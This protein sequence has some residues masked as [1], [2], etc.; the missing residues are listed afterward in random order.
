MRGQRGQ[1]AAGS[2]SDNICCCCRVCHLRAAPSSWLGTKRFCFT[3]TE[4]KA[5]SKKTH[6]GTKGS[7][8]HLGNEKESNTKHS[9]GAGWAP[10]AGWAGQ[11]EGCRDPGRDGLCCSEGSH[12][13]G[14]IK[15]PR[16][17]QQGWREHRKLLGW[18]LLDFPRY[19][20]IWIFQ[21]P[22]PWGIQTLQ[23]CM[24][25]ISIHG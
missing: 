3:R 19:L 15:P 6:G 25:L 14:S 13:G 9:Q 7:C 22:A 20:D 4:R 8:Q 10:A 1:P 24:D 18:S 17:A 2:C 16:A 23:T 21:L 5:Q 11:L 12:V